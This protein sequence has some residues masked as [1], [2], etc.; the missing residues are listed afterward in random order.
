MNKWRTLRT[1]DEL[2]ELERSGGGDQFDMIENIT[3]HYREVFGRDE[4]INM[5]ISDYMN[6]R[7]KKR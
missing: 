4:E 5:R 7:F 3:R 2:V 1:M 6:V